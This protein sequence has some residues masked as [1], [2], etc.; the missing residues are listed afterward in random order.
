[1]DAARAQGN[2]QMWGKRGEW[3]PAKGVRKGKHSMEVTWTI[4]DGAPLKTNIEGK[5]E[6]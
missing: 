4:G 1:M 3:G 6:C 5:S 2:T